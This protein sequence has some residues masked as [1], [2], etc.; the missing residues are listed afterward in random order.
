[1]AHRILRDP[2]A[3]EWERCDFP[4]L[5]QTCLGDNPYNR[6]TRADCGKECEICTRPFTV[7][8][9]K[10]GRDG[11]FKKTVICQTCTKLKN[12]CQACLLDLEYGLPVQVRDTAL[13]VHSY[14][15][16]PKSDV[17][18]EYYAEEYDRRARIGIDFGSSYGKAPPN[19]TIRKLQRTTTPYDKRNRAPL[20]SFYAR[21]SCNRG[22]A[23]AFTH[24]MP[25]TGELSH[26]NIKDRYY[27]DGKDPVA[28]KLLYKAGQ[29]SSLAPPDD[30]SIKTLYIC[31]LD[32]R[33]T[34][35]DLVDI[36]YSYGQI[37]SVR[38]VLK[39]SCAFVNYRTREGAERAAEDLSN[40]LVIKGLR[41]KL[42][43]G[44]SQARRAELEDQQQQRRNQPSSYF[45]PSPSQTCY[46]SMDPQR[47]GAQQKRHYSYQRPNLSSP[48]GYVRSPSPYQQYP[49]QRTGLQSPLSRA[50]S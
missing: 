12:V 9:W 15:S 16:I 47:M 23:C 36:F 28:K 26:Q 24:E 17:N 33:V 11:R 37:E 5:C 13:G 7:Y 4:I 38:T 14:D 19:D 8:R 30:K 2:E 25:V 41:L 34:E 22:A 21:G 50:Q 31:G 1:M 42:F 18:R 48:Y 45:S 43:W 6:M 29:M 32:A 40:K 35:R 46:P 39:L 49:H 3:D 44:K 10:A 27:G 20:C